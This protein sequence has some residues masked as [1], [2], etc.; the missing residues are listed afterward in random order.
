MCI[1]DP[2]ALENARYDLKHLDGD[3][4]FCDDAYEA[5]DGAHAIALVTQ[6]QEYC[7]LDFPRILQNMQRP[8]FLFDGR[9]H[10]DH[11]WLFELGFNVFPIGKSPLEHH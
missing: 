3:L 4:A 8:A 5:T 9:N 11:Q 10:L 6:W 7:E 2:K 1:H